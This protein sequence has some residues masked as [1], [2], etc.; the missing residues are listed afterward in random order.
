MLKKSSLFVLLS[1]PLL[2]KNPFFT[3]LPFKE[4]IIEYNISGNEKGFQTLYVKEYGKYRVYYK[5]IKKSFLNK[6]KKKEEYIIETP[7]W[8]YNLSPNKT[9]TKTPNLKYLLYIRYKELSKDEQKRVL[10]NLKLIRHLPI[11]TTRFKIAKDF[12]TINDIPCDLLLQKGKKEC[13]GYEG[14]LLLK[15]KIKFLGYNHT[16]ILYNIFETKTDPK[17]YDLKEIKVT[18]DKLKS[19][20]LYELSAKIIN[21][22]KRRINP[23]KIFI[24]VK[25]KDKDV[26]QIIQEGIKSLSNI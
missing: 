23:K 14:S 2:A 4:A 18:D 3:T 22:L 24:N 11:Q 17:L 5:N 26:N 13:Y 19:V 16:K 25:E 20:Q 10:E 6:K 1:L 7:K 8:I 12:T 15:S 9:A 21:F